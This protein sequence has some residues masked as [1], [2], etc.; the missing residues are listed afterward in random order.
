M[1]LV[2]YNI[3]SYFKDGVTHENYD[4]LEGWGTQKDYRQISN[5]GAAAVT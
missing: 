2:T 4:V 1:A 3:V 5:Q